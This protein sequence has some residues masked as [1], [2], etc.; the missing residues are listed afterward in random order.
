MINLANEQATSR[1]QRRI[2]STL[3]ESFSYII[4]GYFSRTTIFGYR[5]P[6]NSGFMYFQVPFGL[7]K[8]IIVLE[9]HQTGL[10]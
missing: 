6:K 2:P 4:R 9:A 10:Y 5:D 7:E 8:Y 1:E 3:R